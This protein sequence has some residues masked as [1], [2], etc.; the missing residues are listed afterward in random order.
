M[1]L[2]RTDLPG[3]ANLQDLDAERLEPGEKPLQR[4]LIQK[5]TV[6]N[7]L[8]SLAEAVSNSKSIRPSG[9]RIPVRRISHE[10]RCTG[11]PC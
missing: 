8:N 9:E 6:Q 2:L 4:C 5:R 11:S 3:A 7:R 10:D 1:A